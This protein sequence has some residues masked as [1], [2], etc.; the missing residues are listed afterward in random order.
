MAQKKV[1][2]LLQAVD[3]ITGPVREMSARVKGFA[4]GVSGIFKGMVAGLA[5]LGL[6]K[7]FKDSIEQASEAEL[8]WGRLGTAVKNAGVDFGQARP[9]IEDVIKATQRMTV[10]TDDELREA[11]TRMMTVSGD[12]S[13]S[14]KNLGLVADVAAFKQISVAD[15]GVLVG[16]AMTGNE[17]VFKEFGI[18]AGTNAEKMEQ[19]RKATAGFAE[20]EANTFSGMLTRIKNGWDEVKRATGEAIISNAG[21]R[22]EL[23]GMVSTLSGLEEWIQKNSGAIGGFATGLTTVVDIITGSLKAAFGFLNQKFTEWAMS[24]LEIKT[25]VSEVGTAVKSAIGG[26]LESVGELAVKGKEIL[27]QFF[28]IDLGDGVAEDMAKAGAQMRGQ[29]EQDLRELKN[30]HDVKLG[31]LLAGVREHEKSRTIVTFE[32]AERRKALTEAGLTILI[33]LERDAGSEK[34]ALTRTQVATL[35][36]LEE[37]A[38]AGR[39]RLTKEQYTALKAALKEDLAAREN[40]R[41]EAAKKAAQAEKKEADERAAAVKDAEGAIEDV[42]KLARAVEHSAMGEHRRAIVELA[43]KFQEKINKLEDDYN[44]THSAAV[45]KQLDEAKALQRAAIEHAGTIQNLAEGIALESIALM[46]LGTSTETVAEHTVTLNTK[47]EGM[48]LGIRNAIDDT[49]KWADSILATA[50]AL[51]ISDGA[52]ADSVASIHQIGEGIKGLHGSLTALTAP[53]LTLGGGISGVLGALSGAAGIVKGIGGVIGKIFGGESE[54]ARRIRE[55]LDR[56]RTRIEDLTQ[57]IG[58]LNLNLTG[59]QLS[60]TQGALQEFFATGGANGKG[61]GDRLGGLLLKRGVNMGDLD[62]VAKT[63]QIELRPNG[64]LDP[65]MLQQLLAALGAIEPTQFRQDY[66]GKRDQLAAETNIS[67]LSPAEQARRLAAIGAG[68]TSGMASSLLGT[69]D[70]STG[71]GRNKGLSTIQS[72]LGRMLSGGMST[73]ELGGLTGKE[74]LSLL[75]DLKDLIESANQAGV[76][77]GVTQPETGS[78]PPIAGLLGAA[79]PPDGASGTPPIPVFDLTGTALEHLEHID[80]G[81]ESLVTSLKTGLD[82]GNPGV[83]GGGGEGFHVEGALVELTFAQGAFNFQFGAGAD[84]SP[85]AVATATQGALRQAVTPQMVEEIER[86][87]L[88]NV[89]DRRQARGLPPLF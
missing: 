36:K 73:A 27:K 40:A 57:E 5:A 9:E 25:T 54:S 6:V 16:K 52:I 4:D 7:F 14:L 28:G 72:L 58:D 61:W 63:L 15:A 77:G 88:R 18:T 42:R 8:G 64:K 19:L 85:A 50:E 45:L 39:V 70:L 68:E 23:G 29:A 12:Y 66:R 89:N 44:R 60:G 78:G 32:E 84:V 35:K 74:F 3:N 13:G 31:E 33:G 86:L 51:G 59:K 65:R 69:L 76:A 38:S 41:K 81:I 75:Q 26:I 43:A 17:R 82:Q 46:G 11:L 55:A 1:S 62:E 47:L 56:N 79:A 21:M 2:V 22:G 67:N 48:R 30:T 20:T 49:Y 37:D 80:L 10:A 87:L 53:G 24:W 71:A 83:L 34:V